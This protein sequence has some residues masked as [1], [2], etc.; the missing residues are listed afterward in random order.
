M[1]STTIHPGTPF[2]V[3]FDLDDTLTDRRRTLAR[4]SRRFI[5]DFAP[6][7]TSVQPS[8]ISSVIARADAGGY[9]PRSEVAADLAAYLPWRDPPDPNTL[10][11]YWYAT[12]PIVSAPRAGA[13]AVLH[14]LRARGL[15]LAI[16]TNGGTLAQNAKIDALNIRHCFY[17]ILIS[18]DAGVEKPNPRIFHL[19]LAA[20]GLSPA[21]AWHIGDHPINDALGAAA[22]GLN[23][24]W[25]R[26]TQPWPH[27]YPPPIHQIDCLAQLLPMLD[28]KAADT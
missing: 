5:R 22:A 27:A 17:A 21:Q 11:A 12:F 23:A 24:V 2:G 16:I 6:R 28:R 19:A 26:A 20:L 1:S 14:I 10:L 25:L 7:L 13:L 9:R 8:I 18:E 4:F 3:C 15:R